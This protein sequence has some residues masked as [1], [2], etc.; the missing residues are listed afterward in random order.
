[1]PRDQRRHSYQ[2]KRLHLLR[3]MLML[4]S[5]ITNKK[6]A[7]N[8]IKK[9]VKIL[10]HYG[11]AAYGA[12]TLRPDATSSIR[13]RKKKGVCLYGLQSSRRSCHTRH[14][15][16]LLWV[17]LQ[18]SDRATVD[19]KSTV[20]GWSGEAHQRRRFIMRCVT[21]RM[22]NLI[23]ASGPWASGSLELRAPAWATGT[24]FVG[25]WLL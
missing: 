15:A 7:C 17:Y 10:H 14:S 21:Y 9:S 8:N 11:A 25:L 1:M 23:V 22:R 3:V 19:T 20:S 6:S 13:P 24:V 2:S 12:V 16:S 4:T 18:I 5:A